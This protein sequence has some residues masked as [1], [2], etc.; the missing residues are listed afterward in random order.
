VGNDLFDRVVAFQL[1]GLELIADSVQPIDGGW[2]VLTPSLPKVWSLNHIRLAAGTGGGLAAGTGGG[3]A[4]GAGGGLAAG[5]SGGRDAPTNYKAAL[6]R[7]EEYLAALPFRHLVA[8]SDALGQALAPALRRE[9]FGVECEVIMAA[10]GLSQKQGRSLPVMEPDAEAMAAVER[11]W[12]AEDGRVTAD[13]VEHM[14]EAGKRE[15]RVWHERHFGIAGDEGN[16]AAITKLRSDG[17]TAQVEDVYTA[18]EAR[19]RGFAST[20][21][22]HAL[23]LARQ[24][25]HDFVFIGADDCDWPKH[26]YAR[27][28]FE[29]IGRRWAFHKDL[30]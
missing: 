17:R 27:L 12:F 26:L 7:A 18:P 24:E 3:L 4:A 29:P 23:S 19:G 11:R 2:A 25:G 1:R 22:L 10:T 16:L 5:A 28:G 14:L 30:S 15:Q 8:D 21:V 9:G 20:L 13:A 6:E